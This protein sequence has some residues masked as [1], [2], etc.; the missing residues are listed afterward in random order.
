MFGN[1]YEVRMNWMLWLYRLF[2]IK[3]RTYKNDEYESEC[4]YNTNIIAKLFSVF[5]F[6]RTFDCM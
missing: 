3:N 4:D 5:R 1:H 2:A 6:E